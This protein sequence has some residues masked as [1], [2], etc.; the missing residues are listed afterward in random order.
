MRSYDKLKEMVS[1]QIV[2]WVTK[3]GKE[4]DEYGEIID[5]A[6]E[7]VMTDEELMTYYSEL[8]SDVRMSIV[9]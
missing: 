6:M 4:F 8:R 2:H 3:C 1:E 9:Y 5:E 7:T